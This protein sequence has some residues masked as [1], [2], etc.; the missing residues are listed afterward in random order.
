MVYLILGIIVLAALILPGWWV[1]QTLKKYSVEYDDLP[2]TGG[3]LAKHLIA[4]Y[5][6]PVSLEITESGDHYDPRDKTVRLSQDHMNGRSLSAV[7]V[8]THEVGHAIQH[9]KGYPLLNLRTKLAGLAM[10]AERV[11]SVAFMIFPILALVSRSPTVGGSILMVAVGSMLL[12]VLVH[13]VTLPVE[14][15]A[16]FNRALPILEE[17]YLNQQEVKI[18]RKILLAAALTYVAGA[19]LSMVNIWRWLYLLRG[20]R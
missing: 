3:E 9:H 4:R 2:G 19:A 14:F 7:A 1:K 17:G 11:G 20:M 5:E 12:G 10:N 8:A 18:A 16:S 6:L 13:L 15:D